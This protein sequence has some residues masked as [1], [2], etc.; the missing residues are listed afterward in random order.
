MPI[1][2]VFSF[3]QKSAPI[4]IPRTPPTMPERRVEQCPTFWNVATHSILSYRHRCLMEPCS[5]HIFAINSWKLWIMSPGSFEIKKNLK[6]LS[7]SIS[8]TDRSDSSKGAEWTHVAWLAW[9]YARKLRRASR[10]HASIW[11]QFQLITFVFHLS[12]YIIFYHHI[13]NFEQ[14]SWQACLQ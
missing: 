6:M 8:P 4:P 5:Q 7:C 2:I 12:S 14:C 3:F 13:C 9:A 11:K 1:Y 10:Y